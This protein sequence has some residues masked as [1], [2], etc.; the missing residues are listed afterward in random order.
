[1][2]VHANSC[3]CIGICVQVN[4]NYV[5]KFTVILV[6]V[7]KFRLYALSV[8]RSLKYI[9]CDMEFRYEQMISTSF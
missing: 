7:E 9:E 2:F 6:D 8:Y 4:N 3:V 1:M 5:C